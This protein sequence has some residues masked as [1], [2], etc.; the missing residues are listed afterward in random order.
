VRLC[1]LLAAFND[2]DVLACDVQNAYINAETKKKIWFRSGDEMGLDKGKVIVIVCALYG[3]K[4]SGARWREHMSQ[5]LRDGGFKS[6]LADPD[7]WLRAAIKLDGS[8]IYEYVL[9]Y[10]DVCG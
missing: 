9:C 2:V 5:T 7:L 6:C 8:K 10:V 1:F 4:L 3:L